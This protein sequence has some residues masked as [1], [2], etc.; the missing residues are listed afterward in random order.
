MGSRAPKPEI[1]EYL[2]EKETVPS[3]L[4]CLKHYSSSIDFQDGQTSETLEL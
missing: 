1:Q 4:F 3:G 2:S